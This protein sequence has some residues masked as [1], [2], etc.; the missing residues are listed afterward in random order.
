MIPRPSM[1]RLLQRAVV[2]VTP[3]PR[4]LRRLKPAPG[5]RHLEQL[6]PRMLLSAAADLHTIA[7]PADDSYVAQLHEVFV[8][9][10]RIGDRGGN[11]TWEL[12]LRDG[13]NP[14]PLQQRNLNWGNNTPYSFSLTY[15]PDANGP[16]G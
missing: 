3:T 16:A 11:A 14:D 2:L 6:E 13:P 10:G 1:K 4:H 9:E 8:A 7:W 15:E 12:G 5:P